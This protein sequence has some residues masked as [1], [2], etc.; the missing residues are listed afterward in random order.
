MNSHDRRLGLLAVGVVAALV[1]L[2]IPVLGADPSPSAGAPG[3][4]R[5][6]KGAKADKGPETAL[7]LTGTVNRTTDEKGRPTYTMTVG[8]TTWEL[9][10][11]PK[12]YWRDN[13]PLAAFV[14]KSVEVAGTHREGETE[15]D[16]DTIDGKALRLAGKP[17]WA[18]GPRVVG[19]I[20]PGWKDWKAD[21]KPG[22][23]HGR[24]DAPGQTKDEST[25]D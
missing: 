6:D 17:P 20:H 7:T 24:D 1:L 14:G 13:N 25:L 19:K 18:G 8:G 12:W 9:S 22:K 21:G 3:Q 4:S 16:V 10:A 5:P 2:A 11:G 23:G 15:L